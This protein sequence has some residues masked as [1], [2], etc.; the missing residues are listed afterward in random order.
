MLGSML[1]RVCMAGADSGFR[2]VALTLLVLLGAAANGT[3][4]LVQ[5]QVLVLQSFDRGNIVIDNFTTNFH[6]ELDER[7]EQPV[8]FVQVVVGPIGAVGAPEEAL[9]N[10]VVSTFGDGPKPDLIVTMGGPASIFARKYRGLLFPDTPLLFAAVDQRYLRDAPPGENETAVTA[11]NDFPRLIDDILQVLPQTRQVFVIAGTG[12][13]GQFWRRELEEPFTRF[14]GRLTFEWLDKL[15]LSE[16]LRRCSSLPANSAIFYLA[17]GTDASGTAY[18]DERV[19]A[20]LHAT[21]DAPVFGAQSV[22][23]GAGVVGGSMLPMDTLSRNTADVALR[24]LNGEPPRS[25]NT[26]PQRPGQPVFD[27]RELERWSIPESRLPSGSVVRYRA[28][29]LWRAYKGTV[30]SA[31]GALAV[32]SLL[33]GGLLYQ[34]RARQRAEIESRRNLALAADADR[35]QTMSALA[36][37]MA[38]ELGQ[39]LSSMIHNA[40]AAR[41]M[42]SSNRATPE[43]VGEIL[44]D[45]ED[46]GVQATQI[47]DRHRTM[48]RSHQLDK[49][50]IDVHAVIHESLA[51]VAH[52]MR[53]RQIDVGLNLSSNRGIITGDQVLLQQVLVNLLMNAMDAMVDTPPARRRVTISTE[54]T[55]TDV[56]VSVGDAG[57]GLPEQINGALFTPFVTTKRHG[58][59]IG[60]TITR[61]IIEAHGG[62]IDAHNNPEGGATF[63]VTL[64]RSATPEVL[65]GSPSAA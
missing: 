41:I 62:T 40:Q 12:R 1:R 4:Q 7:T 21:A 3:A 56:A 2:R 46:E 38:H 28:P 59:G 32:Q 63:T 60:L 48:L 11:A 17:F 53:A 15:S 44:S 8:N 51:M 31:V 9:V 54:V 58:L 25:I 43:T 36:G 24:L 61:S 50:P 64:R 52:D 39:P 18:A 42:L 19:L 34:R 13:L 5:K 10:F 6:V 30:L 16:I 47:I 27:W 37:S 29:S 65:S 33:I 23:L 49:K 45:I 26:P 35:R 22:Y 57:T 14:R 20:E 55:A